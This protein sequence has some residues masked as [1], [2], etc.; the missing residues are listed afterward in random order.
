MACWCW[1]GGGGLPRRVL[2]TPLVS[3]AAW[4]TRAQNRAKNVNHLRQAHTCIT[5]SSPTRRQRMG[6]LSSSNRNTPIN[7]ITHA[8]EPSRRRF[9]HTDTAWSLPPQLK[10][11]LGHQFEVGSQ[12]TLNGWVRS[13]R[14]QKKVAFAMIYDGS[15]S[16]DLQ[17][18]FLDPAAC[19]ADLH[20]GAAVKITGVLQRNHR[21]PDVVELHIANAEHIHIVGSC[22]A[23]EYP[24]AGKNHSLEYLREHPH[25]RGRTSTLGA[26]MRVRSELALGMH[27][28]FRTHG[29]HQVH[30]P[31]ITGNDCEGGGEAFVVM[32]TKDQQVL[33]T[34][35]HSNTNTSNASD[36]VNTSHFFGSPAYLTVSGQ[37]H[38]ESLS[39]ALSRVY[40]LGPTFR[41]ENS[42][43]PRHLAEFYMLEA[44]LSF[45]GL[46]ETIMVV[47]KCMHHCQQHLL[48]HCE[49]DL[50]ILARQ[51]TNDESTLFDWSQS[52]KAFSRI[53]YTD[54][55]DALLKTS[56][57]FKY[58]V[59]WGDDLK[60]EHEQW[61]AAE[62]Y[63][64]P[65]F[66]TDYPSE[67]K[68]FYMRENDDSATVSCFDLLVPGVG[69]LAG[70]SAR[71]ERLA[72]LQHRIEKKG[73][74]SEL[75]W[76]EDLRQYGS[77]P[78]AGFGLGFERV[79]QYFTGIS[80]IRDAIPFTRYPG[81]CK[82]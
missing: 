77:V 37:L 80:N 18:V 5:S 27:Q 66:V 8:I 58:P 48:E 29:F 40:V 2:A 36:S 41:A 60:F 25:L 11:V 79:V 43:T 64:G 24:L 39:A 44:E 14:R 53:T 47:E 30:T 12:L 74:G 22:D 38:A 9:S 42:Q 57:K 67:L 46:S 56:N 76:Y 49:E 68:P 71:E 15:S 52:P 65:V 55:I 34:P 63:N 31:V 21:Q 51:S 32:S 4:V 23:V 28:F 35:T 59:A 3:K 78:H 73:L 54:A 82:L 19:P 69:E 45:V 62:L 1:S 26:M 81:S 10:Q 6:L 20:L 7:N 75:K 70:G 17:L 50:T 61:L 13:V 72:I 16:S 33:A